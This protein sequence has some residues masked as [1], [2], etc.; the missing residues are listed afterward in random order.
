[1]TILLFSFSIQANLIPMK[2]SSRSILLPRLRLA[3]L[4][5]SACIGLSTVH[6]QI[7]EYKF[8]DSGTTSA[9]TGSTTTA[10][11]FLDSAGTAADLHGGAGS[12]VSGLSG[13]KAFDNTASTGMGSAGTGG[14]AT[15][16][17][18]GTIDSLTSFTLQGW[19]Y[20]PASTPATI[21]GARLF[22]KNQD[23]NNQFSVQYHR[24]GVNGALSLALGTPTHSATSAF[25]AGN[26]T[27]G[28]NA[29]WLF[30]A[31][32]YDGTVATDNVKFYY[33]TTGTSVV[34]LGATQTL[35]GGTL[36]SN[37]GSFIIGNLNGNSRPWDG[38]LDN[39]RVYG[40]TSGSGGALSSSALET[41][42]AADA[43][44]EPHTAALLALGLT[45]FLYKGRRARSE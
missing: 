27:F 40:A 10:V 42:R 15:G 2:T 6:S 41:L 31:V 24:S 7:L 4:A 26:A 44:P 43:V 45:F 25:S 30:F 12:G 9:S 32:T 17:D 28:T 19:L 11:S 29:A 35:D 18:I 34:Q 33:G 21:S 20:I 14:R 22:E 38:L 13:D 8:N 23:A 3:A 36:G 5:F 1:M 39:M 16:G 37:T